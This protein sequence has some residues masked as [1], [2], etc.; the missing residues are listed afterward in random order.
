[1]SSWVYLLWI[2]SSCHR[3]CDLCCWYFGQYGL[4]VYC[5]WLQKEYSSFRSSLEQLFYA[6]PI[7]KLTSIWGVVYYF[8]ALQKVAMIF[9][10]DFRHLNLLT[11]VLEAQMQLI[12]DY[13]C[14]LTCWISLTDD[15][16]Y[17]LGLSSSSPADPY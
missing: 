10:Q 12:F 14:A 17:Y 5:Y 11:C 2:R 1:M 8:G 7:S 9:Q 3:I 16:R 4:L 6:E 13:L 15:F